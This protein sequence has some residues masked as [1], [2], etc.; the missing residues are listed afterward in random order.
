MLAPASTR[1]PPPTLFSSAGGD[2]GTSDSTPVTVM[3]ERWSTFRVVVE[4]R[5]TRPLSVTLDAPSGP[6]PAGATTW[7]APEVPSPTP[8]STRVWFRVT[9]PSIWRVPT[10]A[11]PPVVELTVICPAP[12]AAEAAVGVPTAPELATSRCRG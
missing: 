1:V 11:A 9:G 7:T 12:R 5:I 10:A 4:L 3:V 2:R 6:L 8:L